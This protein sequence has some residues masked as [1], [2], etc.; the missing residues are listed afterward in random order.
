MQRSSKLAHRK[1]IEHQ[2]EIDCRQLGLDLELVDVDC[3]SY[4]WHLT[5]QNT[6]YEIYYSDLGELSLNALPSKIWPKTGIRDIYTGSNSKM[7]YDQMISS[8]TDNFVDII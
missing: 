2:L 3:Y 1:D 6:V 5:H 7:S 8:L 4:T